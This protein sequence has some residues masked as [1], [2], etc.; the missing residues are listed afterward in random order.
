ME[1]LSGGPRK[2][3]RRHQVYALHGPNASSE[4]GM[5]AALKE[6]PRSISA[7]LQTALLERSSN[8]VA[9]VLA[10]VTA[11]AV[12]GICADFGLNEHQALA[13]QQV[14]PWFDHSA[15]SEVCSHSKCGLPDWPRSLNM[16]IHIH[17]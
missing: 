16:L 17:K 13:V 2:L 11:Q 10:P 12:Q 7:R 5:M 4:L 8:R 1:L 9:P 14:A 6:M 3:Q 15:A